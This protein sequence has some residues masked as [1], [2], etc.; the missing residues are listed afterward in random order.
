MHKD[1]QRKPDT[2]LVASSTAKSGILLTYLVKED[3]AT[4]VENA[5]RHLYHFLIHVTSLYDKLITKISI[6]SS[7]L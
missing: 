5:Y 4:H 2:Q 1:I 6:T 3:D 7:I